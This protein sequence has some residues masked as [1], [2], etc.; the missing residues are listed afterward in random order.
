MLSIQSP[1]THWPVDQYKTYQNLI[2]I[3]IYLNLY[4]EMTLTVIL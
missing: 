1:S 4:L 2:K 3:N